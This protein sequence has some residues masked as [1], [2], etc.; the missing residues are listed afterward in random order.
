MYLQWIQVSLSLAYILARSPTGGQKTSYIRS[1]SLTMEDA[2]RCLAISY[3]L[4]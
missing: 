1:K 4:G 3:A 2:N